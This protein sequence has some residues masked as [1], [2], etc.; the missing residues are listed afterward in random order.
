MYVFGERLRELRVK[1]RMTQKRLADKLEVTEGTISKY[2]GGLTYP[3]FEGL[4]ELSAIFNVSLDYLCGVEKPS[5]ISAFGLEEKQR[6]ILA[7]LA[8]LFREHNRMNRC[9]LSA[10]QYEIIGKIVDSFRK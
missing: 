6:E 10:E 2:E 9:Q 8:E 7:A 5:D 4:R 3:T 1:A